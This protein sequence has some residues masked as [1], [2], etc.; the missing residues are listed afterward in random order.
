MRRRQSLLGNLYAW[1]GLTV[2][3]GAVFGLVCLAALD[4]A[5][6]P[7]WRDFVRENLHNLVSN[8]PI[9][10]Q[11]VSFLK[12]LVGLLGALGTSTALLFL[13]WRFNEANLPHRLEDLVTSFRS[14]ATERDAK[15][16]IFAR[17]RGVPTMG[18]SRSSKF[19]FLMSRLGTLSLEQEAGVMAASIKEIEEEASALRSALENAKKWQ[20]TAHLLNGYRLA[21]EGSDEKAFEEF[22]AATQISDEDLVSRDIGAGW[23]RKLGRTQQEADLLA[24]MIGIC[25]R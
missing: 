12:W 2:L 18:D 10:D 7:A 17:Q 16:L 5:F 15:L 3:L 25:E 13:N 1:I 8:P 24:S 23:A 20:I 21:R 6:G 19:T 4:G 9:T 11:Q 22:L 14:H